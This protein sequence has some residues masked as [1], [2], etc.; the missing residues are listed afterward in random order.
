MLYCIEKQYNNEKSKKFI[1]GAIHIAFGIIAIALDSEYINFLCLMLGVYGIIDASYKID[2]E[3]KNYSKWLSIFRICVS[4]IDFTL[5]IILI[6]E[7]SNAIGHH[8][9]F[10]GISLII[11]G[12]Q[13]IFL[14][15]KPKELLREY[16]E[17]SI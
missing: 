12:L 8:M 6:L 13:S 14:N 10:L 5:G 16:E 9:M 3:I 17:A 2:K 1:F 15:M 4:L 7:L 11:E